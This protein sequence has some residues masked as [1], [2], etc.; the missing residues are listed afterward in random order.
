M[1]AGNIAR[2][3]AAAIAQIPGAKLV[4]VLATSAGRANA[5]AA[6]YGAMAT[7]SIDA[8]LSHPALQVVTICTPSGT[9]GELGARAAA[10]GKHVMVEKPIEV[11]LP[12]A[13]ALVAACQKHHVH[14]GVIFQ[15]RFLPAVKLMKRAVDAGRLGRLLMIDAEVKWF[16]EKAY[17]QAA[18]WRGTRALDGGGAMINQAIHTVDLIRYLG[19]PVASVFGFAERLVHAAIETEDTS[20]A[21]IKYANGAL[22]TIHASTSIWPGFSRRVSLH[23]EKGSMILEGNDLTT[24]RMTDPGPEDAEFE[25]LRLLV[26][27]GS[28]GARDPMNLDIAGHLE[29]LGDFVAAISEG[30]PPAVDGDEGCHALEVVLGVYR[31]ARTGLPVTFPLD[32]E[33]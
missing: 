25:R 24:W 1:G 29:Q 10:A 30:R 12:K 32:E 18:A 22:G 3:H 7:T 5:L 26:R 19:G 20:A 27:D 21:V 4:A 8:F 6:P 17:Y 28:D 9:H 14:L 16:R 13:R 11:T 23:G 15:S 31:S 2:L 33:T